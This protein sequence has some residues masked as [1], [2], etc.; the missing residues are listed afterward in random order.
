MHEA[1]FN[2]VFKNDSFCESI[3]EFF[4]DMSP[5]MRWDR[6]VTFRLKGDNRIELENQ[7]KALKEKLNNNSNG[8]KYCEV[9]YVEKLIL[10]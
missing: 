5:T 4:K 2:A 10:T 8:L 3:L 6:T 7:V 1:S 9:T